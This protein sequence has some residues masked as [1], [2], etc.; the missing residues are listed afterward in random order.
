MDGF[1]AAVGEHPSGA[2]DAR[3][4]LFGVLPVSPR[5]DHGQRRGVEVDASTR[6]WCLASVLV[7]FVADGDEPTIDR[8]GRFVL[9]EVGPA[10]PKQLVA[11]DTGER[12]H[13]ERGEQPMSRCAT[14]KGLQLI[15]GPGL[16]LDLGDGPQAWCVGDE[17]D[18]AV[19]QTAPHGVGE[20][21]TDHEVDLVDGFGE[22]GDVSSVGRS[23]RSYSASR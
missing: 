23:S 10:Q 18:V 11:A 12:R 9:V 5:V 3:G 22:S 20:R 8:D 7:Q 14:Q 6:S 19:D 15:G 16:L 1:A 4:V 17:R 13:P 21:A 2:V